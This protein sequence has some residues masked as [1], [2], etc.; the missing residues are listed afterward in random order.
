MRT[1]T[2]T[3]RRVL[4]AALVILLLGA[5]AEPQADP[6]PAPELGHVH[7]LGLNPGD[8][9]LHVA[10]HDGLFV[11]EDGEASRI[12]EATHDLMGFSVAGKNRFLAS[13]HPVGGSLPEPM[14]L[15][16]SDD[17]GMT[18]EQVS[19]GG[20]ADLHGL[21]VDGDVIVAHDSVGGRILISDDGGQTFD[22][23]AE[24]QALDVALLADGEVLVAGADGALTR[25][26]DESGERL[27]EAPG[28]VT[29]DRAPLGL[30]GV[31]PEGQV[32]ISPDAE[33]WT[34]RGQLDGVPAALET[35]TARWYAATSTGIYASDDEGASWQQLM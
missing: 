20:E 7:G 18:W 23:L 8:D 33:S 28:L 10:T 31:G 15:V 4:L 2:P 32:W 29:I 27:P 25:F 30:V 9:R 24:M 12:G 16:H 21:D 11:L 19:L 6:A 35:G 3:G 17:G 14:G 1:S 34:S 22:T 13:G 5:C 26:D